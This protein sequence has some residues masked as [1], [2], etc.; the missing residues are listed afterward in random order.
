MDTETVVR[1]RRALHAVAE[2]VLAGPQYRA[3]GTIRLRAC[4]G[5]FA[6]VVEPELRV[7]G[8]ELVAPG[9]VLSLERTTCTELGAALGF[10]VGAPA[11]LYHDGPGIA[12]GDAVAVDPSA[13]R[14]IADCFALGDAALR[15]L[16][17]AADPVIWPEHFDIGVTVDDVNYGISPGDAFQPEPYAYIGPHTPP[18]QD[19]FWNA[20]FGAAR[21]VREL[22][23]AGG[24][25]AFLDQGRRLAHGA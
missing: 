5:G 20:P 9:R 15:G 11:G 7:V 24:L 18:R 25:M 21:T 10:E 22:G 14:R 8:A 4:P 17:A 2:L 12:P 13:A 16:F 23:D 1:T 3:G 6:T 19:G